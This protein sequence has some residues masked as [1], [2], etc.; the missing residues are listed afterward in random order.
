M[1]CYKCD[2]NRNICNNTDNKIFKIINDILTHCYNYESVYNNLKIYANKD[3]NFWTTRDKSGIT[4]FHLLVWYIGSQTVKFRHLKPKIYWIFLSLFG[5]NNDSDMSSS[6][7]DI[8]DD[9]NTELKTISKLKPRILFPLEPLFNY[10]MKNMILTTGTICDPL[11]TIC[12]HLTQYCENPNDKFFKKIYNII[13]NYNNSILDNNNKTPDDYI[14]IVTNKTSNDI[15]NITSSYKHIEKAII[16]YLESKDKFK[17]NKCIKC[18]NIIDF[19]FEIPK[20]ICFAFETFDNV[21]ISL[22]IQSYQ[23]RY[24]I[25]TLFID[26]NITKS[27]SIYDNIYDSMSINDRHKHI[28]DIYRDNLNQYIDIDSYINIL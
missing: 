12:H 8:I 27:L 19:S 22:V 3:Y 17:F 28:I 24:I 18:K 9:N 21:L 13:N 20:I 16:L 15:N 14:N 7:D 1:F 10:D 6:D 26:N 11:H 5:N 4:V 23:L 25:N 2:K